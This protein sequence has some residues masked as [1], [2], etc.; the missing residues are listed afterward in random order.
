MAKYLIHCCPQREWYVNEYLVPSML[1]QGILRDD[2]MVYND[3]FGNGNLKAFIDSCE[4]ALKRWGEEEGIWHLQDDVL[5]CR[6]FKK[7]TNKYS[8][9]LICAFTCNYDYTPEPGTHKLSERNM[10]FSFPCIRIP[11]MIMHDFVKWSKKNLWNNPYFR[12]WVIRKRGDDFV[13][14]EFMYYYYPNYKNTNIAPNLVEHVDYLLGG[15]TVNKWRENSASRRSVRSAYWVD[16]PLV[17]ELARKLSID[18][19]NIV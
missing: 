14:R 5:I 4:A 2:I 16:E 17:E 8:K 12:E 3:T 13:F 7:Q 15:T 10:W 1:Q 19:P 18:K 6:D 11:T 9:G